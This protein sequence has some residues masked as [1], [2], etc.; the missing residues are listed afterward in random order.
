MKAGDLRGD[1][2][3]VLALADECLFILLSLRPHGDELKRVWPSTELSVR[4]L[5]LFASAVRQ[6]NATDW[7]LGKRKESTD[8]T[9]QSH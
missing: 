8:E 2:H 6:V 9:E 1:T 7:A 4:R 3:G 5:H